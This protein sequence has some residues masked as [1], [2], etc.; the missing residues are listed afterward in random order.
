MRNTMEKL[1]KK[2]ITILI[3][4][5]VAIGW[6][7]LFFYYAMDVGIWSDLSEPSASILLESSLPG[8]E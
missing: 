6:E 4:K 7:L 3:A 2:T 8:A 5:G 1:S